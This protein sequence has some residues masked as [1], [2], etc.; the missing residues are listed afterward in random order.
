MRPPP[1]PPVVTPQKV[2]E[3]SSEIGEGVARPLIEKTLKLD[4]IEMASSSLDNP[5]TDEEVAKLTNRNLPNSYGWLAPL[6][7]SICD[8]SAGR[9]HDKS[10]QDTGVP[11][12]V[13]AGGCPNAFAGMQAVLYVFMDSQRELDFWWLKP[14]ASNP[15]ALEE[16]TLHRHSKG[17]HKNDPGRSRPL[18]AQFA[19]LFHGDEAE[20]ERVGGGRLS[21]G[22]ASSQ[23][24]ENPRAYI[25]QR[26]NGERYYVYLIWQESF[27]TNP[28]A[29]AKFIAGKIVYQRQPDDTGLFYARPYLYQDG[30]LSVPAEATPQVF[31]RPLPP[32]RIKLA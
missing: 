13:V 18:Y 2:D 29:R 1:L 27:T 32:D 16:K 26:G 4:A 8:G 25:E 15:M 3:H 11:V 17:P 6:L 10:S 31:K 12:F 20:R 28:F 24:A 19:A 9:V 23:T 14:T 7:L 21:L 5:L 22:V 30:V